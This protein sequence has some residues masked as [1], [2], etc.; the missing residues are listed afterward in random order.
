MNV[1]VDYKGYP[2]EIESDEIGD[3]KTRWICQRL[4]RLNQ[5]LENLYQITTEML[6]ELRDTNKRMGDM[7]D[8]FNDGFAKNSDRELED[9]FDS[10][11]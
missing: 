2:K 10:E 1:L 3:P 4:D 6:I 5:N 7:R 9:G 8:A 11:F